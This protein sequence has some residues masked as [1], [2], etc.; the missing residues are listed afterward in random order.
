MVDHDVVFG[1]MNANRRRYEAAVA[2]LAAADGGWLDR[3]VTPRGAV[4]VD[5]AVA[6]RDD[7][8]KVALDV[9]AG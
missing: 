7:D 9:A 2:A 5:E 6:K 3:L 4:V 1:T 8:V